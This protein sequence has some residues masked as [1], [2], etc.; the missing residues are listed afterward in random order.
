MIDTQKAAARRM[1]DAADQFCRAAERCEEAL[2]PV[3]EAPR[4]WL[5]YP[6]VVNYAFAAELALKGLLHVHLSGAKRVHDLKDLYDA[7]P[8]QVKDRVRGSTTAALFEASLQE[9]SGAFEAWRYAY[10]RGAM[11]IS[12]TFISEL[13]RSAVAALS[14]E[15]GPLTA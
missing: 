14:H 6:Q 11:H 3:P 9:V 2:A 5:A 12:L 7:L 8:V 1:L 10:E 4:A 15:V 13:A